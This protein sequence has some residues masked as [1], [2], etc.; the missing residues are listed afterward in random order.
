MAAPNLKTPV[1]ITGKTAVYNCTASLAA[2][3][4]NAFS[5]GKLLKINV[6]RASNIDGTNAIDL[7]VSIYRSSTH[8]YLSSGITIPVKSTFVLISKE[9]FVYLEEGDAIFAKSSTAAKIDLTI[10]YEDIS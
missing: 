5:S 7:D 1:T 6:I 2:A 9:D 8:T 4:S 10:S 3:L